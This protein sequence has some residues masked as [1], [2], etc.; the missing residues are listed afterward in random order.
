MLCYHSVDKVSVCFS[1]FSR[2]CDKDAVSPAS[3]QQG[4][5]IN[6]SRSGNNDPV[7][8]VA[9]RTCFRKDFPYYCSS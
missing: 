7:L 2:S 1:P 4:C 6:L 3:R 9:A 5:F 8:P